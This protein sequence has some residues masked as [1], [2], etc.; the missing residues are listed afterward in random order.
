M[1]SKDL[2]GLNA[3]LRRLPGVFDAR[4]DDHGDA[5]A[6]VLFDTR[7]I[8]EETLRNALNAQGFQA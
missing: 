3:V 6:V 8:T 7:I 4:Q 2:D 5:V 1:G